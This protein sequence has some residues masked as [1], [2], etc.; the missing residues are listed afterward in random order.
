[1]DDGEAGQAGLAQY[2]VFEG[3]DVRDFVGPTRFA[4]VEHLPSG[5]PCSTTD[6][7]ASQPM[8]ELLAGLRKDYSFVLVIGT[9][10]FEGGIDTEVLAGHAGGMLLLV[11]G[12]VAG[13]APALQ[14]FVR[15]LK[16]ANAPLLGCVLCEE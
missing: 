10:V 1:M 6:L 16:D 15:S 5:G 3:Q 4:S 9:P 7:L 2:L 12:P 11:N 8:R 13:A 14:G